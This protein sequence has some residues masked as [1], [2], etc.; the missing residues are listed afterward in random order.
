M[1][2]ERWKCF[3]LK[4]VIF[5][6]KKT[7]NIILISEI[8]ICLCDKMLPQKLKLKKR[9]KGLNLA[10][11]AKSHFLFFNFNFFGSILS[12]KDFYNF[13]IS[14]KI[15][16]FNTNT[17]NF[18]KKNSTPKKGRFLDTNPHKEETFKNKDKYLF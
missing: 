9:F 11:L 12:L 10:N 17:T 1:S 4:Q 2:S 6:T 5:G 8:L 3:F 14:L 13:E 7:E 16:I 15:S 18:K